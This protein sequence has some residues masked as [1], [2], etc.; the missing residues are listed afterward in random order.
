M[1]DYKGLESP[2]AYFGGKNWFLKYL[3]EYTPRHK[4]CVETCGGSGALILAKEPSLNDVLND[5]DEG[6]YNFWKVVRDP[7]KMRQLRDMLGATP[8]SRRQH[9]ECKRN[10]W[11]YP[12]DVSRAWGWFV[13]IRQSRNNVPGYWSRQ[14]SAKIPT[15]IS[16]WFTGINRVNL[17]LCDRLLEI[18]LENQHIIDIIKY[19]DSPDTWF[20]IDPPY[21]WVTRGKTRYPV[22]MTDAEHL[23]LVSLLLKVKGMVL[24]FG[25]ENPLYQPLEQMGWLR[26]EKEKSKSSV[27]L[28]KPTENGSRAKSPIEIESIW[29]SPNLVEALGKA[30]PKVS[31]NVPSPLPPPWST[32]LNVIFAFRNPRFLSAGMEQSHRNHLGKGASF[33]REA[34]NRRRSIDLLNTHSRRQP[35]EWTETEGE[36]WL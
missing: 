4:V 22:D 23:A 3:P 9:A 1:N 17:N 30:P 7:I 24:L 31:K 12:D 33:E 32:S 27:H 11:K 18:Q 36:I 19:F 15:N 8:Y 21:V 10:W 29:L 6:V 14:T 26:E 13:A 20:I 34:E 5:L 2:L 28:P 25:K 16:Q 35:D